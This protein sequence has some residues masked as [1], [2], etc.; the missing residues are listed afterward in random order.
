MPTNISNEDVWKKLN[1]ELQ[2]SQADK[3]YLKTLLAAFNLNK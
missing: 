2:K 1:E 3:A